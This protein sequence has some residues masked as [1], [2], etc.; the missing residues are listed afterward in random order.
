MAKAR[1]NTVQGSAGR[2]FV[3]ACGAVCLLKAQW[4]STWDQQTQVPIRRRAHVAPAGL[5]KCDGVLMAALRT[6]RGDRPW[7]SCGR[8]QDYHR[9]APHPVATQ[10]CSG[11]L[12]SHSAEHLA[13]PDKGLATAG[14]IGSGDRCRAALPG[15]RFTAPT[16]SSWSSEEQDRTFEGSFTR[17]KW[18]LGRCIAGAL[19]SSQC[20]LGTTHSDGSVPHDVRAVF[21]P[22]CA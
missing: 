20:P 22:L 9:G 18:L 8:Q 1:E 11:H 5:C 15:L 6:R 16:F 7:V 17:L 10:T 14:A 21:C 3:I 12:R 13:R 19:H 4:A 2:P